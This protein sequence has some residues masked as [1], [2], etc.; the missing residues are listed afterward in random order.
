MMRSTPE[1]WARTAETSS[2]LKTTGSRSGVRAR[3]IDGSVPRSRPRTSRYRNRTALNAWFWVDALT[4]R[5][6]ASHD[7]NV[8]TSTDPMSSGWRFR[9]KRMNLRIQPAYASS[10]LRLKCRTRH[11]CRTRSVAVQILRSVRRLAAQELQLGPDRVITV[12]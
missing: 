7:R 10:V 4:C 9:W 6:R 3:A 12:G 1:L 2:R 5:S 8:D 11:A